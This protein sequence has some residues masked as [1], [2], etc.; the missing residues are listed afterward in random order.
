MTFPFPVHIL[1]EL[2]DSSFTHLGM[3]P[4]NPPG[5]SPS[6]PPS[7]PDQAQPNSLK[8][9]KGIEGQMYL[10]TSALRAK[11]G[12]QLSERSRP[13]LWVKALVLTVEGHEIVHKMMV[14]LC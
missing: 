10:L 7:M 13:H 12:N 14:L 11:Q 2:F 8:P 3:A 4:R 1:L 5:H 6:S 9:P